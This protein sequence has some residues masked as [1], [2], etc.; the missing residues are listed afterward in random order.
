VP[1]GSLFEAPAVTF[2]G[3]LLLFAVLCAALPSAVQAASGQVAP[4]GRQ[5]NQGAVASPFGIPFP[6]SR[7]PQAWQTWRQ[8]VHTQAMARRTAGSHP[9]NASGT[10][11]AGI[12]ETIAGAVPFQKPVNALKTGFGQ[13]QSIAEDSKGNLYVGSCDMRVV[14]KVDSSSNVTVYAGQPLPTGPAASS[15]DG[16]PA[17]SARISCPLGLAVDTSGNLYIADDSEGTVREVDAATGIIHTIASAAQ[18]ENPDGLSLD[19][20]GDLFMADGTLVREMNL[21]TGTVQTIAG[22]APQGVQCVLSVA[23]PCPATQVELS[24]YGS[25]IAVSQNHLYAGLNSVYQG[26][27]PVLRGAIVS[28]DLG[29]G[30]MQ[31]LAGG[32]TQAGT[33]STFPEIGK[34]YAPIGLTADANGNVYFTDYFSNMIYRLA[35]SDH[36][37]SVIAGSSTTGYSGDG[38]P[39]TAAALSGPQAI[40]FSPTGSLAFVDSYRIRSFVVG[41]NIATI[42]G[43]GFANYSGDGGPAIQA[44]L[45]YP[46]SVAADAA[47]N[48]FIADAVNG[49]VRRIDGATGVITTIAGGGQ[50]GVV[51]DSGPATEAYL[52]PT[53]LAFD[54]SDHLYVRSNGAI[55]VVDPKTNIISTLVTDVAS[56][57]GLVFDGDKTLYFGSGVSLTNTLGNGE[58]LAADVTTGATN[59]IAGSTLSGNPSGDGGPATQATFEAVVGVALDNKGTLF[60]ADEF[61]NEIRSVDLSTGIIETAAGR[62]MFAPGPCAIEGLAIDACL[63]QPE[64]LSYDGA[65]HLFI[66]DSGNNL[67]RQIDLSNNIITTTA[68][69]QTAGFGGDG[70]SASNAMFYFPTAVT[71][72]PSGNLI[73]AD[74]YNNRVRRVLLHPTNLKA[75]LTYA[76]GSS[77]SGDN[78]TFTATYSGLSF[79]FA[80]TGTVTFLSGSTSLGTGTIASATDG[81]GNY[82]ATVTS[83]SL[84]AANATITAQYSGDVHYAA[85]TTTI[86]FQQLGPSY[87]ISAYPASLTVKQGSSGSITFT[88]TPLNG[89]NQAISFSCDGTTLPKGVACSFAPAS[90]TPNGAGAVTATLTVQTTGT[91]VAA[92]YRRTTRFPDWLPRGGSVLALLL[93]GIPRVRRRMWLGGAALMLFPLCLT[94]MLGCGGGGSNSGTG[95][96]QNANLTPPGSYSILV[97]TLAGSASGAAPVTV[98]LTVT[99]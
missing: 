39:P 58:V 11:S 23:N 37:V 96:T 30:M 88:V 28:I 68:G 98:S 5:V 65:G 91:A 67:V 90:V 6:A 41:G 52:V 81:S 26:N 72:D 78:V 10:A 9:N 2:R 97:T 27:N 59:V 60:V 62:S 83:T 74:T 25:N 92:L 56:F 18:P 79:G 64:G 53:T 85:A 17:T 32:G 22:S 47:G 46:A 20:A 57:G 7:D 86:A 4:A 36:T 75:T 40:C 66:A 87:T 95:S 94:G 61:G 13:I 63:Y 54:Q 51:G 35:A 1:G 89:F 55:R 77:P 50:Y 34:D 73:I 93:L 70:G 15:G 45:D 21:R 31:L 76:G 33:S 38:G 44:G 99:E 14:L 42:A 24:V 48:I 84:P 82:V 8:R 71:S 69:N 16:G 19:G 43:D 49:L 12:I 29:T 80:P 3:V